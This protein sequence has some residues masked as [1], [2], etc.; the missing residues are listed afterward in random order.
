MEKIQ[1]QLI[2]DFYNTLY[3]PQTGRLFC[4]V[5][6]Y[7]E[8]SKKANLLVLITAG[9]SKRRNL[10]S[11]LKINKYFSQ[12]IICKKKSVQ[13][14]ESAIGKKLPAIIIGDRQ[15]EEIV[16][17]KYLNISYIIVNPLLENPIKTIERKLSI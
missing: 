11:S 17:A 8:K 3:N 4:G 7:L 12:I 13:V 5:I 14:F 9:G 1:R 10:I 15:D 2:F 16:I 6:S